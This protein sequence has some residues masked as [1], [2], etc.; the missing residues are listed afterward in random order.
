[1]LC[2][3]CRTRQAKRNCPA[4]GRTICAVCCGSKRLTEIACPHTCAFLA[5]AKAHPPAVVRR[6]QERDLALL[7]PAVN[8]LTES[9]MQLLWLVLSLLAR[10]RSDALVPIT[11]ADVADAVAAVTATL[12]TAERGVIYE[13]RPATLPGQRIASDLNG[14]FGQLSQRT[15]RSVDR[16]AVAVLRSVT[17]LSEASRKV[18]PEGS[19]GFLD[20]AARLARA[21]S[22]E[23]AAG[24]RS[25]HEPVGVVDHRALTEATNP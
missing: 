8:G 19:R 14:L 25:E 23:G 9:Q 12:E 1:M 4:V 11:D 7:A 15:G 18:T 24:G 21:A 6:Q 13:H 16:D 17:R 3:L 5:A 2:P 20:L 22:T 10:P